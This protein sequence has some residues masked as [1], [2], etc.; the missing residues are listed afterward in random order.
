MSIGS[1]ISVIKKQENWS[2]FQF[3]YKNK[4][5][6]GYVYSNHIHSINKELKK[7]WID[8]A[9]KFIHTPYKWGGRS[10]FGIDCS[11]LI[12]LSIM[13]NKN[14]FFPRNS[15]DQ[16]MFSQNHGEVTKN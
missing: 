1:Q 13:V 3:Y 5:K 16:Y 7:N 11:S 8:L 6:V 2:S 9:E 10:F 14:K 12:Q 15:D 4:L